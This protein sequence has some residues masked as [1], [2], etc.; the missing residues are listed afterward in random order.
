M[1]LLGLGELKG[2]L[3]GVN[4]FLPTCW[5]GSFLLFLLLCSIFRLA[6]LQAFELC[7]LIP[8]TQYHIRSFMWNSSW[9]SGLHSHQFHFLMSLPSPMHSSFI[10]SS[11]SFF[12]C[13][14]VCNVY[15]CTVTRGHLGCQPLSF[16]LFDTGFP[17]CFSIVCAGLAGLQASG[18]LP[19]L[20]C[21]SPALRVLELQMSTFTQPAYILHGFWTFEIRPK[22]STASIL[23]PE[24]FPQHSLNYVISII[25]TSVNISLFVIFLVLC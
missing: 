2:Q 16:T 24:S 6:A 9:L 18:I 19:A 13:E 20:F 14:C 4:S 7:I 1:C 8:D 12:V 22:A 3:L 15:I 11:D 5:A 25:N 17:C 21:I 23:S 10:Y